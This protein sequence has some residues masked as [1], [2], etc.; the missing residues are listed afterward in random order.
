MDYAS[1]GAI[2]HTYIQGGWGEWDALETDPLSD[3]QGK[4][5]WEDVCVRGIEL[6]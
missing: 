5:H 6:L 2:I 3:C 1:R 4:T